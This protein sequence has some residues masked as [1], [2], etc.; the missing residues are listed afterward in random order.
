[1]RRAS[2]GG[3]YPRRTE[4]TDD[5]LRELD[6]DHVGMG[7]LVGDLRE[8]AEAVREGRLSV[9]DAYTRFSDGLGELREEIF[10]HF[11]REEEGLFPLVVRELPDLEEEV[12]TIARAHDGICGAAARL[13]HLADQGQ[14]AFTSQI[15]T[16]LSLFERF[17]R[18]FV[19]HSEGERAFI[20]RVAVRLDDRQRAELSALL[21]GL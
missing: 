13:G 6:H 16:V 18:S 20:A 9:A 12:E 14:E 15:S 4:M 5:A 7:R 1:M 19:A 11:A 10:H 3:W 2:F 8:T 17:D 21:R